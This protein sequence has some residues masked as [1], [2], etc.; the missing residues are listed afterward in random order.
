MIDAYRACPE[1]ST[2]PQ[3]FGLN[4]ET[5]SWTYNQS[6]GAKTLAYDIS[7]DQ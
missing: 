7:Y 2:F 4:G 1:N 3:T 6:S 5:D